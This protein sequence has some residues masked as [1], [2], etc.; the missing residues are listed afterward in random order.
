MSK[1]LHTI[2][3]Q[4]LK[5]FLQREKSFFKIAKQERDLSIDDCRVF[6]SAYHKVLEQDREKFISIAKR[7]SIFELDK[8]IGNFNL[9]DNSKKLLLSMIRKFY[10]SSVYQKFIMKSSFVHSEQSACHFIMKDCYIFRLEAIIDAIISPNG[11]KKVI[12]D[13]KTITS[14]SMI[15]KVTEDNFYWFQLLFYKYIFESNFKND[16]HGGSN[17]IN[18]LYLIFQ[19][20]SKKDN[21][22]VV[23][24]KFS[25]LS[26]SNRTNINRR[27][28]VGLNNYMKLII[29]NKEDGKDFELTRDLI[30]KFFMNGG[31][32]FSIIK[33]IKRFVKI[34]FRTILMSGIFSLFWMFY[35]SRYF[36]FSESVAILSVGFFILFSFWFVFFKS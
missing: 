12:V 33:F 6:G 32:K 22:E 13:Y 30:E 10:E 24:K 31:K 3:F 23:L 14:V 26:K 27:F 21:F 15:N 36:I 1:N 25:D 28:H 29:Q 20:K 4:D 8:L 19:S 34:F 35:N 2:N 7:N 5:K 11:V 16:I 9:K 18:D 17:S